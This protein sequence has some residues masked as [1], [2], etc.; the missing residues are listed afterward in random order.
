M[1]KIYIGIDP[2]ISSSAVMV[3][4]EDSNIL[5]QKLI[6]TKPEK[7][8]SYEER[9]CHILSEM[10]FIKNINCEIVDTNNF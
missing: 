2:S 8:K 6:K 10:E 5:D 9:V 4:D 1:K 3:L 7:F